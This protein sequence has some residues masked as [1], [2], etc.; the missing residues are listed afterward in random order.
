M[1][2]KKNKKA[3][4]GFHAATEEYRDMIEA[5][6]AAACPAGWAGMGGG[7]MY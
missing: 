7:D 4:Y 2:V 5:G 1:E 3:A 6:R